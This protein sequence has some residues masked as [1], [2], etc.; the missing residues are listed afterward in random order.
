MQRLPVEK[1]Q[2]KNWKKLTWAIFKNTRFSLITSRE[3]LMTLLQK[4]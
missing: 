4:I 2:L 3:A 1:A